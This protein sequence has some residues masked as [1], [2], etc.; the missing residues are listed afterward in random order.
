MRWGSQWLRRVGKRAL[1]E[2]G[3]SLGSTS[4]LLLCDLGP[5][6]SLLNLVFFEIYNRGNETVSIELESVIVICKCYSSGP[7]SRAGH[8]FVGT[9]VG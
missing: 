2:E 6:T 5:V 8:P 7:M 1:E 9:G 4:R 3:G